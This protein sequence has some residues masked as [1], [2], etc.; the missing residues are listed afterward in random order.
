MGLLLIE[1]QQW[2]SKFDRLRQELAET[3]EVLKR[4]QSSHLIAFSQP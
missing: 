2:S 1:K 4:D 3:Q